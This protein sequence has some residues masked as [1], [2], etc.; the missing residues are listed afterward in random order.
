MLYVDAALL[1]NLMAGTPTA[2]GMQDSI[3][4]VCTSVDPGQ[5]IGI[6]AG[7]VNSALCTPSTII[8]GAN[9]GFYMWAD[10]VYP[11]PTAHSQFA[12][13]AF[14]RISTRW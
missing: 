4:P 1:F 14:S 5:G 8:S 11:T 6:G 13:Y 9:Y 10:P 2:Y 12:S 3:T 7:Q